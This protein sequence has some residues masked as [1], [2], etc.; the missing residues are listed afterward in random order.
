MVIS[1]DL[2]PPIT[3][4]GIEVIGGDKS[5]LITKWTSHS[6]DLVAS[7]EVVVRAGE[8][9]DAKNRIVLEVECDG[10]PTILYCPIT[11]VG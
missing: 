6:R 4:D 7:T 8:F 5:L 2:S 10:R 3:P 11:L 1:S 9:V